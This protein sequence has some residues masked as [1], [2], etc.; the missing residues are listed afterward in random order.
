MRSLCHST[1]RPPSAPALPLSAEAPFPNPSRAELRRKIN[2]GTCFGWKR[3]GANSNGGSF[4]A[5]R[6]DSPRRDGTEGRHWGHGIRGL[7]FRDGRWTERGNSAPWWETAGAVYLRDGA[8]QT[9]F[10]GRGRRELGRREMDRQN[11]LPNTHHYRTKRPETT[12]RSRDY[13]DL[14]PGRI[15]K[16]ASL[17]RSRLSS[18]LVRY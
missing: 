12:E 4:S 11:W 1:G 9:I 2:P 14:R 16:Q 5:G 6:E 10:S 3:D 8:E 15:T 7:I 18:S 13:H 17:Y